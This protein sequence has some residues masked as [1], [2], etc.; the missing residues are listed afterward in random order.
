MRCKSHVMM[1]VRLDNTPATCDNE[2][3]ALLKTPIY[4]VI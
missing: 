4:G 3:Y 2:L 1:N